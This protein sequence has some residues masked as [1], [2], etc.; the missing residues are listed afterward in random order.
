VPAAR[1]DRA[2]PDDTDAL[3]CRAADGDGPAVSALLERHRARL[4]RSVAVRINDRLAARVD[5]SDIVQEALLEAA[6][7]LPSFAAERPLPFFPWL[8][9]LAI[10]RLT[11]HRQRAEAAKRNPAREEREGGLPDRSAWQLADRLV[12]RETNPLSRAVRAEQRQA[13]HDALE[14]LAGSDREV[15]VLRYLEHLSPIEIAAVLG[16]SEGAVKMRHLRALQRMQSLLGREFGGD[17]R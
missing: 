13:V 10:Q 7:K 12:G 15:L 11:K 16:I 8:R 6:A 5:P 3:L 1:P 4:R 9:K 14:R 2:G 17:H